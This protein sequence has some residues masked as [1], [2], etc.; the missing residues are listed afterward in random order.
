MKSSG[1]L[2]ILPVNLVLALFMKFTFI[3]IA[4]AGIFRWFLSLPL[5]VSSP[6]YHNRPTVSSE[7]DNIDCLYLC[8]QFNYRITLSIILF[9][10]YNSRQGAS[11]VIL[12]AKT[13]D[14]RG[15]SLVLRC[16]WTHF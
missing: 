10:T 12:H 6:R 14:M 16:Y 5:A 11:C 1:N 15:F 2:K 9:N 7:S 4:N 13:F 3:N 8:G